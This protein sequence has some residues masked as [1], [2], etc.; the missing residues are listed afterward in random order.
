MQ[1]ALNLL[2]K[3]LKAHKNTNLRKAS[4][5]QDSWTPSSWKNKPVLQQAE[6]PCQQALADEL[7]KVIKISFNFLLN[8]SFLVKIPSSYRLC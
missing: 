8:S 5:N 4:M 1:T 7:T 3:N 2:D 6:Y